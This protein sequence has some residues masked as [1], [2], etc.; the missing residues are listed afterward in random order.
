MGKK[1]TEDLL[2]PWAEH[3]RSGGTLEAA[4]RGRSEGKTYRARLVAEEGVYM[5]V[6]R[7]LAEGGSR[8]PQ[9]PIVVPVGMP[10]SALSGEGEIR[11]GTAVRVGELLRIM[12]EQVPLEDW[13]RVGGG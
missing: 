13:V 2:R 8:D 1:S 3:L 5:I 10:S 9:S 7:D 12:D 4:G 11:T 6:E